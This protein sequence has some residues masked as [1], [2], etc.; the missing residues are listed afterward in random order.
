MDEGTQLL[1]HRVKSFENWR[2]LVFLTGLRPQV[3]ATSTRA[4]GENDS[5]L[6]VAPKP[7]AVAPPGR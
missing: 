7:W 1:R 4:H 3:S 5:W 6:V 2:D